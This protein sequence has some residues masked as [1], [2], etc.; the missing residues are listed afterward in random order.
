MSSALRY[1]SWVGSTVLV[2]VAMLAGCDSDVPQEHQKQ[3]PLSEPTVVSERQTDDPSA[4]AF[5]ANVLFSAPGTYQSPNGKLFVDIER[6]SEGNVGYMVWLKNGNGRH[7]L[8]VHSAPLSEKD[9]VVCWDDS[10]QPWFYHPSQFVWYY[11]ETE[12]GFT[13]GFVGSGSEVRD[14]MPAA[15]RESLPGNIEER[16]KRATASGTWHLPAEY[17]DPSEQSAGADKAAQP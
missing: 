17:E 15:F 4:M 9:L 13:H 1:T 12:S 7:G 10:G 16:A 5:S 8:S 6:K 11:H 3:K 2:V 14:Q